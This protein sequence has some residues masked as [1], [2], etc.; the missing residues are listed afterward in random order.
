[1][2]FQNKKMSGKQG[3]VH[4]QFQN[5]GFQLVNIKP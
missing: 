1:M 2:Y 3:G 5:K 4:S